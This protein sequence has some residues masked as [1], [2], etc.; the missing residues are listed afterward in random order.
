[1]CYADLIDIDNP[2]PVEGGVSFN[3]IF[4]DFHA[5]A[6]SNS[7]VQVS[8]VNRISKIKPLFTPKLSGLGICYACG[9]TSV[10]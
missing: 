1:M 10:F 7:P 6:F 2:F 9:I 8:M 3:G 5:F 4:F